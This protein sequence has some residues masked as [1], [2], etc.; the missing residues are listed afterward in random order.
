M[1]AA[2]VV[3]VWGD[4][5][6]LVDRA[7]RE[8]EAEALAGGGAD[9][10]R[11]VFEAPDASPSAVLAAAKTL[12]FLGGRRL[13]LVRNA[14][15]WKAD[16]WEPVV[17]YLDKPNPSTCLLFI[18]DSLDKRTRAGKAL[19]KKARVVECRKPSDRDLPEW[20]R[21][22]AREAGLKPQTGA[23]EALAYRVG[24]DLQLLAQQI[25]KLRVYAG[26]GG[27]V[28]TADVEALV[29]E[30]R[31]TTVFAYCDGLGKRDLR[32]ALGAL[33]RILRLGE[34]PVKILFMIHRHFRH[35]WIVRELLEARPQLDRGAAA[36]AAGVPPFA[37]ENLIGQ[38]RGW[39][40]G[41][42]RAAFRRLLAT[43]VALKTG[44]GAEA[45]EG[46]TLALCGEG[47][48]GSRPRSRA[49]VRSAG[50]RA[51]GP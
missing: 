4:E 2:P 33:R 38:A 40:V 30:S 5:A 13:V 23:L 37:A 49:S 17:A 26:E 1:K 14:H 22:L 20:A 21:R 27:E 32:A 43:D 39:T 51:S 48:D 18:A 31:A 15:A 6:Y 34:P 28:V 7:L 50:Y 9:F 16:A 46:L 45:L 42:L 41:A 12:P 35:L 29:G 19:E 44:S 10:N 3:Y 47:A 36:S 11:E 25:E 8:V 24:P